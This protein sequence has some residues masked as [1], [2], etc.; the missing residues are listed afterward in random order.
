GDLTPQQ[1]EDAVSPGRPQPPSSRRLAYLGRP[2][3]D[4]SKR[5]PLKKE[6]PM[7]RSLDRREQSPETQDRS[8]SMWTA[9]LLFAP[10]ALPAVVLALVFVALH[11]WESLCG[12]L[13]HILQPWIFL[14]VF[15]IGLVVHEFL[16]GATW[17][18]CGGRSLRDIEFGFLW[19][20]VTPFARV[21]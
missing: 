13:M 6:Q 3:N 10:L 11:G 20:S 18:W 9:N 1:T 15:V 12:G 19:R 5:H 4:Q 7:N 2:R 21:K 17:A 8:C 14:P 16:H